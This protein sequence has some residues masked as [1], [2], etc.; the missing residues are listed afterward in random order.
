MDPGLVDVGEESQKTKWVGCKEA[1]PRR[2]GKILTCG[3]VTCFSTD[4]K[5]TNWWYIWLDVISPSPT[6]NCQI[7]F[8][9]RLQA[10]RFDFRWLSTPLF[11]E[12]TMSTT[13]FIH[14]RYI[15]IP[16]MSSPA[17]RQTVYIW[18]FKWRKDI[19]FIYRNSSAASHQRNQWMSEGV[20]FL[21]YPF[22][23]TD[24]YNQGIHCP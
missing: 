7:T 19:H 23:A 24:G 4:Q 3:K 15:A 9:L 10:L 2:D 5:P 13:L 14:T 1:P 11:S 21:L 16:I 6:L 12:S 17:L 22:R 20:S 8:M 18:H